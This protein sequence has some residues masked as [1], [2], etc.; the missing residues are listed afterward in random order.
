M[1]FEE[2]DMKAV[3]QCMEVRKTFV[4]SGNCMSADREPGYRMH[5]KFKD[6][7]NS[8]ATENKV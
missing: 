3:L 6:V 2:E 5:S 1:C 4:E 7:F 8:S